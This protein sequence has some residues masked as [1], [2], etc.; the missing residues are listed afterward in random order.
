MTVDTDRVYVLD[1]E[2][3][4]TPLIDQWAADHPGYPTDTPRVSLWMPQQAPY[5]T[6]QLRER[7][8]DKA[9]VHAYP[10]RPVVNLHI[11]GIQASGYLDEMEELIECAREA[12]AHA[13]WH[14][15]TITVRMSEEA[16]EE[17]SA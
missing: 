16:A 1:D 3:P 4:A 17:H 9:P 14:A 15:D 8:C 13:R 2:P 12:L 7:G 10:D 6:L 5:A 11:F